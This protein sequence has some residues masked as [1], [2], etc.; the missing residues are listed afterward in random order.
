M[1]QPLR[2]IAVALGGQVTG[3]Q[4]VFPGPG[5]S[6]RDRSCALRLSPSAP[7]G[8]IVFA[9]AGDDWQTVRDFV[10]DR[11]GIRREP[12]RVH[13]AA[14]DFRPAPSDAGNSTKIL[15]ARI[16]WANGLNPRGTIVETYLRS[17]ML[18]LADDIAGSVIRFLPRCPWI[19][20]VTGEFQQLPAMLAPF[21]DIRTNAITAVHRTALDKDGVKIGRKMLGPVAGCAIKIDDDEEI[22]SGIVIGEGIETVLAARHL[23]FR[24]AWALGSA[25]AIGNLPVLPG[26]EGLT[27]L[28]E[29]GDGGAN[30]RAI[31]KVGA[32]WNAA[33]R[34][35][36]VV[37][38]TICGDMN[39]VLRGAV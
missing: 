20:D 10:R 14:F 19:D 13:D 23:G 7:D 28:A 22:H 4:V 36:M 30:A 11:L 5:H 24:P 12:K 39:D 17:R 8:F 32:R 35:V 27:I 31:E 37:E 16:V 9:H 1:S 38:P 2:E 6:R 26:I 15:R 29:R 25:T 3:G 18:D 34:E 21:R 33:G